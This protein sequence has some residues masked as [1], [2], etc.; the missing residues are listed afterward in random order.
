ME[1]ITEIN[2]NV[3]Y[4]L[5]LIQN[6]IDKVLQTEIFFIICNFNYFKILI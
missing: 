1:S 4:F 3:Y 6:K 2:K 5:N